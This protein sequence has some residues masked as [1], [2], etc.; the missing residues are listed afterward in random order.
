MQPDL[1]STSYDFMAA[2]EHT[3]LYSP[4]FNVKV[5]THVC[6]CVCFYSVFLSI[7]NSHVLTLAEQ[8]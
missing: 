3:T 1:K 7:R 4:Q 5:H 8:L 2:L 6:V